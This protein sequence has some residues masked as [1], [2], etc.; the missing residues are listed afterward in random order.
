MIWIFITHEKYLINSI[1][2]HVFLTVIQFTLSNS[3]NLSNYDSFIPPRTA[4]SSEFSII[5]LYDNVI[6]CTCSKVLSKA[7]CWFSVSF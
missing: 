2:K 3:K 5:Y 6:T 7:L 4:Y 1:T